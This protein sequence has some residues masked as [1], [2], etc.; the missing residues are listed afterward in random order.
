MQEKIFWHFTA[1]NGYF[2]KKIKIK[3]GKKRSKINMK[4]KTKRYF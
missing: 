3:D 1:L 4:N 2:I